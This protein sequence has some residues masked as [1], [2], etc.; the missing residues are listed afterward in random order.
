M[1]ANTTARVVLEE[2]TGVPPCKYFLL[3]LATAHVCLL[4]NSLLQYNS[5]FEIKFLGSFIKHR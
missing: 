5:L 1:A 3:V 2:H 4:I